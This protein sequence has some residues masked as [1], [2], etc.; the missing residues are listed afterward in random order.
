[1]SKIGCLRLPKIRL[2]TTI[3]RRKEDDRV[4]RNNYT[5]V[6]N[7]KGEIIATLEM[8]QDIT[9]YV[10]SKTEL[11]ENQDRMKMILDRN[12]AGIARLDLVG[13]IK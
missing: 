2:Q 3:V 9:D 5:P 4:H 7:N 6:I 8:S 1:M 11:Q 10:K 12:P 13:R